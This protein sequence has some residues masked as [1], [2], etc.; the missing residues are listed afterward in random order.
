MMCNIIRYSAIAVVMACGFSHGQGNTPIPFGKI[1]AEAA[2]MS[3]EKG[4]SVTELWNGYR[5]ECRMQDL[6]AEVTMNGSSIR[7]TSPGEGLG[8][9]SVRAAR[10]G[11][12]RN[13]K[14]IALSADRVSATDGVVSSRRG[15]VGEELRTSGDGIR[16][17]FILYQRPGGK[18]NLILELA[19]DGADARPAGTDGAIDLRLD[20]GRKLV[21]HSLRAI[22]ATGNRLEAGFAL[23]DAR[24]MTISVDDGNAQYPLRIDPTVSDADWVSMG[25]IPGVDSRVN[26]MVFDSAGAL[27][28]GGS[29]KTAGAVIANNIAKWDGSAWSALG[30]GMSSSQGVRALALDRLGNLFAGGDFDSAGNV[31]VNNIAKWDGGSWSA[32]GK[33]TDNDVNALAFDTA[34]NLYVGGAFDTMNGKSMKCVAKWNGSV[35]SPLGS[36][37]KKEIFIYQS[38]NALLFDKAGNLYA[39]GWFDTIGGIAAHRIAMWDGAAWTPLGGGTNKNVNALAMDSTG[40]LYTGGEFDSAGGV[41]AKRI[42]RWNGAAWSA[43]GI[44]IGGGYSYVYSLAVG[45]SG[46]LYAVGGFDTKYDTASRGFLANNIAQWD[47]AAWSGLT[48]ELSPTNYLTSVAL[49]KSG[50]LY[51]GGDFISAGNAAANCVAKWN[52]REWKALGSG[53]NSSICALALD[54][55]GNMYAGGRFTSI[56]GKAANYIAKWDGSAWSAPGGGVRA[57]GEN[58]YVCAI[59]VSGA[60]SVYAAGNFDT[61]G[62]VPV[63]SLAKWDGAAWG[64]VNAAF[65][66][67]PEQPANITALA[68]DGSGNLFA[69]GTFDSVGSVPAKNLA[70][71]DGVAWNALGSGTNKSVYTLLYKGPGALYAG[72]NFDSAGGI[73]VNNIAQWNGTAWSALGKGVSASSG[74]AGYW[75]RNGCVYDLAMDNAGNLYACGLFDTASGVVVNHVAKWNGS[76]WS[77]LGRG[78]DGLIDFDESVKGVYALCLDYAGNLFVAGDFDYAGGLAANFIAQWDGIGWNPLGSGF[79]SQAFCVNDLVADAADN[80]YVGGNFLIAGGKVSPFIARCRSGIGAAR[81]AGEDKK[82]SRPSIAC[83]PRTGLLRF[84]LQ[85]AAEVSYRIYTLAGREVVRFS[86]PMRRGAHSLRMATERL[87]RGAYIARVDAG[88]ESMRVGLT[89]GR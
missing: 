89:K 39:G 5:L 9:F 59:A 67:K 44:G 48:K 1:G 73:V 13:M 84:R 58:G 61:A 19:V 49:D 76:A 50:N 26:A 86:E 70:K 74:P 6:R 34:G 62:G 55:M 3:G 4:L 35:W 72:G 51:V 24:R 10:A 52:G 23:A 18:G 60:G 11:R 43:V 77:A 12:E 82:R 75:G 17:D 20:C 47:G 30:K 41:A 38:C 45:R 22:D 7:S 64:A 37:V 66:H 87:S 36:G 16:Q 57:S 25:G 29:F 15:N 54:S 42:A 63:Q 85:S 56:G 21:Y 69:G 40:V 53:T 8:I 28:V 88:K 46:T 81:F 31:R 14:G 65:S 2:K 78:I 27:Y 33:G 32:L 71:W 68:V 79:N 83:D 80:I